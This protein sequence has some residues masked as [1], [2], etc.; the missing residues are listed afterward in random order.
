MQ[1]TQRDVKRKLA[2]ILRPRPAKPTPSVLPLVA[3]TEVALRL[4]WL[5]DETPLRGKP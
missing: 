1:A 2:K 4:P 3:A 5:R